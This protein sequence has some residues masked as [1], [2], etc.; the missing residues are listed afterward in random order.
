[1]IKR[2]ILSIV[3]SLVPVIGIFGYYYLEIQKAVCLSSE[4]VW[5]GFY[6]GCD[7]PIGSGFYAITIHPTEMVTALVIWGALL[8]LIYFLLGRFQ[9]KGK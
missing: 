5:L 1:M 6:E 7:V 4:G 3:L 8:A 9:E 2:W